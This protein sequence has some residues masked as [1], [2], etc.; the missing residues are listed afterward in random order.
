MTE[1]MNSLSKNLQKVD[2]LDTEEALYQLLRYANKYSTQL[3]DNLIENGYNSLANHFKEILDQLE[4]NNNNNSN[5]ESPYLSS[6]ANRHS[7]YPP[8]N[9]NN[10]NRLNS[11]Y[12]TNY[13]FYNNK[14]QSSV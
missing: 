12:Q 7:P 8:I 5:S 6:Q 2:M 9:N 13:P 10:N 4:V 3:T 11:P 1:E 14:F